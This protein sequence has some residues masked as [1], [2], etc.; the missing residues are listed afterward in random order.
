MRLEEDRSICLRRLVFASNSSPTTE[1]STTSAAVL[2]IPTLGRREERRARLA[3]RAPPHSVAIGLA[4]RWVETAVSDRGCTTTN[5][6]AEDINIKKL[7][8]PRHKLAIV[9]DRKS[10]VFSPFLFRVAWVLVELFASGGALVVAIARLCKL[11]QRSVSSCAAFSDSRRS[12]FRTWRRAPLCL[13]V[14]R[15]ARHTATTTT[16]E[17]R[18]YSFRHTYDEP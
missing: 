18:K 15:S 16:G 7:A 6:D 12:R 9:I 11:R 17:R 1:A 2:L 4:N 10:L 5:A 3:R 14:L 8:A 13:G